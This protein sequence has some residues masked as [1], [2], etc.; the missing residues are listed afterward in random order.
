MFFLDSS[1][2]AFLLHESSIQ[3]IDIEA[4]RLSFCF[5][6]GFYNNLH[7]QLSNC[8]MR[9]TI[10]PIQSY[11]VDVFVSITK[12]KKGRKKPMNFLKFKKELQKDPFVIEVEYYSEFE[13]SIL[14]LG[15]T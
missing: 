14:L 5:S 12:E 8:C 2:R 11:N 1:L 15:H 6:K 7:Q 10:K 3:N 4:S 9:L 13:R